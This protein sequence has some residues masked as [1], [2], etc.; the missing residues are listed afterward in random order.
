MRADPRTIGGRICESAERDGG[1]GPDT[2]EAIAHKKQNT[3]AKCY[4]EQV[5]DEGLQQHSLIAPLE[6]VPAR[7]EICGKMKFRPYA[8]SPEDGM[9]ELHAKGIRGNGEGAQGDTEKDAIELRIYDSPDSLEP[10]KD[11]LA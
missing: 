3:R 4:E 5:A 8:E 2:D 7:E 11:S 1:T 10:G 6:I 9:R